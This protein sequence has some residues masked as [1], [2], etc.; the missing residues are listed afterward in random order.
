MPPSWAARRSLTRARGAFDQAVSE[1]RCRLFTVL[2]S[3]GIGKSR[4]ARELAAAL[5]HEADVLVGRCLPYGEGITY[6]PLREIFAA[7][8]AEEELEAALAGGA[9]EEIFWAVRK[10]LESRAR[11]RPLVLVIEDIHWAEPTLLDLI[12][13]LADWTRDAQLLL[14]CLARPELLDARPAWDSR[15]NAEALT[16]DPLGETEADELIEGLL[17]GSQ[18]EEGARTRIRQVAEGNPLFVEQLLALLAEGGEVDRVPSTIQALLAAR[19]D[20]LPN[21]ERDLLER[22]SIVGLEFEWEALGELAPERRRPAGTH[23]AT[24]VRKELIR[25]HEAIEDAFRFRHMLIRDAAYERIPKELRSD[26]HERV[27]G[28]LDGRGEEFDE[29]V[30]YHLEQAYRSV[31]ELAPPGDRGARLADEA[32]GRLAASG[33]RAHARGDTH[34]A[35]NLLERSIALLPADDRRRLSLLASLGR[36]LLEAGQL[37]RA[38]PVLSEAVERSQAAGERAVATDAAVALCYLRLQ[39]SQKGFYGEIERELEDGIGLLKE[40]GDE[41]GLARALGVAGT[42]RFWRG[43]AAAAIEDLERAARYARE[44]GDRPQEADS[45]EYVLVAMLWGPTPVAQA[46]ERV[47]ELRPRAQGNRRLEVDLLR[48]QAQLE[49]MQGRFDPA[50]EL[51]AQAKALAEEVG[52]ALTLASGVAHQAGY[53]ELL[54]GDAAAA[55][56]W[57]RPACEALERMGSWPNLASIA[58][59]LADALIMQRRD[60]EAH[61]VIELAERSTTAGDADAEIRWRCVRAKLLALRGDVDSGEDFA[62]EAMA[63]AARTDFLDLRAQAAAALGEVLRLAGRLE[64]SVAAVQEAIRLHEQKGNIAAAALL[65]GSANSA[66]R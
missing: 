50:R 39:T 63:L 12:E 19:L 56:R 46:L 11:E 66:P 44:V 3:P 21:E 5:R 52:L 27:A 62:R 43:E 34:A 4:L 47:E 8:G 2:G 25:P 42:L 17:G 48:T 15:T 53:V 37:E 18:L 35:T 54:A 13:H 23:L 58:P 31:A 32:A 59:F 65:A 60:E 41:P 24:L 9:P 22:A 57:L 30:G 38:D 26:L 64:E 45:L 33:G 20:A 55:E 28:W 49:A 51:I 14:L 36:A 29:I 61:A 10:A 16:L 6:W 7:A 40:L 1:R